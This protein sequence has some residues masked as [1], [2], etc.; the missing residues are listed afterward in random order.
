MKRHIGIGVGVL[1]ALVFVWLL[2]AALLSAAGFAVGI[3]TGAFV[4]ADAGARLAVL[5]A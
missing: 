4:P 3:Q 2:V 5:S 1:L